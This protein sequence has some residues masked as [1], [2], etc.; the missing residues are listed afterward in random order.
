MAAILKD[1]E[2]QVLKAESI[3]AELK[4]LGVTHAV[5]LGDTALGRVCELLS[6]DPELKWV[7]VCRE[8]EAFAVAAGLTVGGKHPVVMIQ[9]TGFLES[10]D[11]L[12]GTL[13]NMKLPVLVLI[14]YRGYAGAR[15]ARGAA[16]ETDWTDTAAVFLE[17]TLAAWGLPFLT[18]G[19]DEELAHIG[20]ALELAR[21][22]SAP[23]ALLL[24]GGCV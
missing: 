19:G 24:L 14:S 12:R 23:A 13:V 8:G 2:E 10:G 17:P 9:S 4:R 15:R 3:V 7:P 22:R 5:G 18:L 11:A 1:G 20:E 21:Q 6:A 16:A